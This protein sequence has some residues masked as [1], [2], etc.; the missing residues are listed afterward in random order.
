MNLRKPHKVYFSD[1]EWTL[2]A[3]KAREHGYSSRG[4]YIREVALG[5]M[6]DGPKEVELR[7]LT[8]IANTL[9]SL[10]HHYNARQTRVLASDIR[11][12][13]QEVR[14]YLLSNHHAHR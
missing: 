11:E 3:E 6:R 5:V 12:A 2:V 14:A 13:L 10:S 1:A 7:A 8:R 9:H 4:N